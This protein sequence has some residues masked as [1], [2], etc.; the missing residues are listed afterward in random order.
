MERIPGS[1]SGNT[2]PSSPRKG[3]YIEQNPPH[4]Y[5]KSKRNQ[6]GT[7]LVEL[8]VA[9]AICSVVLGSILG[10]FIAQQRSLISAVYQMDAQSDESRV[11]SY[12]S[13]DLRN[14]SS[15]QLQAGGTQATLTIPAPAT[16]PTAGVITYHFNL[17]LGLPLLSLLFPPSN[18]SSSTPP[19]TSNVT[20]IQYYRQGTSDPA[21]GQWCRH[22]AQ[23]FGHTVHDYPK[24][25]AC[26]NQSRFSAQVLS[27]G[28][29][30]L[31]R[32]HSAN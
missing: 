24:R 5:M 26:A 25:R 6:C 1:A 17:N 9:I 11:M 3:F 12:L 30:L 2:P 13:K 7:S 23:Q 22:A 4:F 16:M 27:H 32:D 28:R 18:G 20:T 31:L 14:A 8:M 19:S 15:V 21:R 10:T 29:R